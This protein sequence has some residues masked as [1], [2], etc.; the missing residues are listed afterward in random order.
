MT[1]IQCRNTTHIGLNIWDTAG[2]ERYAKLTKKY[3]HEADACLVCYDLTD[4][5][6]W[7]KLQDWVTEVQNT[8]PDCL[9]VFVGTKKDFLVQVP[10]SIKERYPDEPLNEINHFYT[11]IHTIQFLTKVSLK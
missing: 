6:S 11:T 8:E 1:Q 7:A 5:E 10:K 4:A 9:I 2:H 3:Y